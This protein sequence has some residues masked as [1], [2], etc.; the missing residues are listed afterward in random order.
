MP[1]SMRSSSRPARPSTPRRAPSLYAEAERILADEAPV[2]P[3]AHVAVAVATV[4]GV[5]GFVVDPFGRHNF[6]TTDIAGGE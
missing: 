2:I 1:G 4:A 3:V 5:T 6:E